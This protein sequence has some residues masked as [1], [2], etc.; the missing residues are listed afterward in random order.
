[1]PNKP[2][3]DCL[4]LSG[5]GAK[6]A[7]G[8]GVAKAVDAFRRHKGITDPV[9]YVG[10]SAG[11]LNAFIL[12]SKGP[13]DLIRFWLEA[14][15]KS[16]LGVGNPGSRWHALRQVVTGSF[17]AKPRSLYDNDGLE[18]LIRQHAKLAALHSPVIFAATDYT[19]G[20]LR[21][22]YS[23]PLVDDFV[24]EDAKDPPRERRLSH[25][26]RI[27]DE[28]MLV[29]AL[30]A[31][32]AIPGFFPPVRLQTNYQGRSESSW[33]IDGGVGNNTPTREAAYFLRFLKRLKRGTDGVVYC[34]KL[35]PP[36]VVQDGAGDLGFAEILTRT[37]DVYHYVHTGPIIGAWNRI[38]REVLDNK[39]AFGEIEAWLHKLN[40][41]AAV[42]EQI[43][44]R[45]KREFGSPGGKA[46]RLDVPLLLIEPSIALG[47]TLDFNP[48]RARDEILHGYSDT[49]KF[50]HNFVDPRNP[51]AGVAIDD[52]EYE[53]LLG[54]TIFP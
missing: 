6:G 8:A 23:S 20:G 47:D 22:F 46:Q 31:S 17:S 35:E 43:K 7:Y 49:L 16:I 5:G 42:R 3:Y 11:A 27:E 37:L 1:M 2:R 36:R 34:V 30:L 38:N 10:A 45:V 52:K 50:L 12:A 24:T 9:C 25:L 29:Q 28:E 4:V 40:I 53:A 51:T 33:F 19:Q 15:N 26:R 32:A 54:L 18:R 48:E 41:P 13:D 14:T 39:R 44:R 21:A